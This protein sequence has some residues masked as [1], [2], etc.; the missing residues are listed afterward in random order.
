[1]ESRKVAQT[2]APAANAQVTCLKCTH[3][4]I[5]FDASFPYGCRALDFKSRRLPQYEVVAASN[6]PCQSFQAK[7]TPRKP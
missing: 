2:P 5:T 6:L 7:A 3:Y 1:M 4:F